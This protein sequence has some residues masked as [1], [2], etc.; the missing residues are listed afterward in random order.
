MNGYRNCRWCQ[1][2][3]CISCEVE[4]DRDYKKAFPDGP[5]PIATIVFKEG[6]N[7]ADVLKMLIGADAIAAAG[8]EAG[9]RAE[10]FVGGH[11]GAVRLVG[12]TAEEAV[13]AMTPSFIVQVIEE[14]AKKMAAD[15]EAV[16]L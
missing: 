5:K 8:V 16:Q 14:N 2:R 13:R 15:G 9:R 7:A 4:S 1:G 11:Q 10:K 6:Q 12:A 3:G